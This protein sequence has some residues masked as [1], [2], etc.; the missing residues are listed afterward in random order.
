[1][2]NESITTRPYHSPFFFSLMCV[3]SYDEA[4]SD[5]EAAMRLDRS[6]PSPY[7]CAGQ[8]HLM[9]RDNPSRAARYFSAALAVDPTCIRAY[10][11]R[12]EALKRDD[13][14]MVNTSVLHYRL[15]SFTVLI[16]TVICYRLQS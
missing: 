12:A 3:P 9:H 1:M 13:K 6:L 2:L 7:I 10:L 8:V 14:V 16:P 5:F 15:Q 11:C 4:L